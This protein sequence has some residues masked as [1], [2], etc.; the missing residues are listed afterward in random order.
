MLADRKDLHRK[1]G[2]QLAVEG[3]I[4]A[5]AQGG[6]PSIAGGTEGQNESKRKGVATKGG[7]IQEEVT[8]RIR[9]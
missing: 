2:L 3:R 4:P 6:N 5:E 9:L 1:D 7:I 8:L